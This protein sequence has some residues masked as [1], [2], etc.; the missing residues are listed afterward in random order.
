M[1]IVPLISTPSQLLTITLNSQICQVKV[2]EK[3]FGLFVDLYMNNE[4]VIGGVLGLNANRIVRSAYL[5][6]LGDLT[7]FDTQGTDDPDYTG[8]GARF[9]LLYLTPAELASLGVQ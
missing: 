9:L 7:F 5:G 1:Q 2:Y 6:F 3:F 4:P 8:L